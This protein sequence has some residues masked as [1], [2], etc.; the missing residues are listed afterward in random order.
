MPRITE[1]DLE[2]CLCTTFN[3]PYN[4][5]FV[6]LHESTQVVKHACNYIGV[7]LMPLQSVM[8]LPDGRHV[9]AQCC[10]YCK[11]IWYYVSAGI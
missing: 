10:A 6:R 1:Y 9:S 8:Q 5:Q 2:K 4:T 7:Q 3:T 11:K